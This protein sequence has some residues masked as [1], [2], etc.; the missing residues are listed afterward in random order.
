MPDKIENIDFNWVE[1]LNEE[2]FLSVKVTMQYHMLIKTDN[3]VQIHYILC[4]KLNKNVRKASYISA[5]TLYAKKTVHNE[6]KAGMLKGWVRL[7]VRG[8]VE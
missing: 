4:W 6:T 1:I 2:I 7:S 3:A 8:Q 5:F